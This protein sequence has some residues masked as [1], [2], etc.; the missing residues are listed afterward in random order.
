MDI[1]KLELKSKMIEVII[2]GKNLAKYVDEDVKKKDSGSKGEGCGPLPYEWFCKESQ[3][4]LIHPKIKDSLW[5]GKTLILGCA[6]CGE[7]GCDPLTMDIEIFP[8][9]IIW[10]NFGRDS[11]N[12]TYDIKFEFDKIQYREEFH[13]LYRSLRKHVFFKEWARGRLSFFKE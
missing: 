1:I 12:R 2:N 13:R 8:D 4:F 3:E 10:S 5:E 9:E 11:S 7:P 6:S